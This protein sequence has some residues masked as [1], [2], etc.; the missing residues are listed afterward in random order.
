VR[1]AG[2]AAFIAGSIGASRGGITMARSRATA[3][4][5][6]MPCAAIDFGKADVVLSP[7]GMANAIQVVADYWKCGSSA[8]PPT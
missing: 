3:S 7:A 2:S 6:A 5:F 1:A 4:D 8:L